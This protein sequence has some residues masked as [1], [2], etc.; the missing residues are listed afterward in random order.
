MNKFEICILGC[1]SAMTTIHH[2]GT[3][4]VVNVDGRLFLI[5]CSE[6]TIH[7]LLVNHIKLS[8]IE[9]IFISHLHI[10]HCQGLLGLISAM[11]L[12]NRKQPLTIYYHPELEQILAPQLQFFIPKLSFELRLVHICDDSYILYDDE[13]VIVSTVSLQHRIKCNAFI[14]KTKDKKVVHV[15]KSA[16]DHYNIPCNS[17]PDI[18]AGADY[19]TSEGHTIHN[20]ALVNIE[21]VASQKY[22]YCSDT[23]PMLDANKLFYKADLLYHDSTF[24]S[25]DGER[26][27]QTHH[28]T[29]LQAAKVATANNVE[30]LMLG[31][32]SARYP[33][34]NVMLDEA[35]TIFENTILAKENLIVKLK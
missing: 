4:Q 1:G 18:L 30:Q 28:S 35:K 2:W 20:S 27:F 17:I 11:S 10:D 23:L 13:D 8:H 19:M 32:F 7:Q 31:H 24:T 25:A 6:G 9:Q 16:I 5:D 29:A 21:Y 3:S 12:M 26:A 34:E 22:V 33:D 14:F 15:N